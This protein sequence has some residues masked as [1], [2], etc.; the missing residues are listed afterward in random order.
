MEQKD[1]DERAVRSIRTSRWATSGSTAVSSGWQL[2]GTKFGQGVALAAKVDRR[3]QS[4]QGRANSGYDQ[5]AG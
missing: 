1:V 4:R 5:W 2:C 3:V